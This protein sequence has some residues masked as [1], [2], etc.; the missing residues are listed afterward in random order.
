MCVQPGPLEE[1]RG[2]FTEKYFPQTL[3][4]FNFNNL[5]NRTFNQRYLITGEATPPSGAAEPTCRFCPLCFQ[6]GTG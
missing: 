4:H 6:T 2:T 3:D 1:L 5:G